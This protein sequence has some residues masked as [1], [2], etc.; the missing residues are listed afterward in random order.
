[1]NRHPGLDLLRAIAVIWMMLFHS[2]LVGG[3]GPRFEWLSRFGWAGVD[4]SFVLSDA[5]ADP[6]HNSFIEDIYYPRWMRLD[7]LLVGV[8]LAATSAD[9]RLL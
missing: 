1:M 7:G 6:A 5:A 3:P 2:C 9:T 8:M 4:I